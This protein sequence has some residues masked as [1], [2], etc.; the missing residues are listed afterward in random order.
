M[1]Y[2]LMRKNKQLIY[3]LLLTGFALCLVILKSGETFYAHDYY[4][5]PFVPVI[6]VLVAFALRQLPTKWTTA[7]LILICT[8]SVLNQTHDL[9]WKNQYDAFVQLESV[10]DQYT[11]RND[12]IAVNCAPNPSTLYFAHRKGWICTNEELLLPERLAAMRADGLKYILICKS[13]FGQ[14][15]DLPTFDVLFENEQF[16]LYRI[17]NKRPSHGIVQV[18]SK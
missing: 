7:A 11:E 18:L 12:R 13:R 14:D 16:R 5:I 8:E 6:V 15:L 10:M 4:I 1:A 3:L 9:R 17:E 2:V